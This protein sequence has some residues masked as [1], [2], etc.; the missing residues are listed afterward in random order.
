MKF[1]IRSTD[2]KKFKSSH[3]TD[4]LSAGINLFDDKAYADETFKAELKERRIR[5]FTPI[6][7][8]KKRNF[9]KHKN[10][11]TKQFQ[12]FANRLNHSSNG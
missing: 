4:E 12:V 11:L 10:A 7:K 3:P 2:Q 8:P 1:V 6:E 9:Q 5:L